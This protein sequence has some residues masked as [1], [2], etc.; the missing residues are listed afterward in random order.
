MKLVCSIVCLFLLVNTS[1]ATTYGWLI[2]LITG[3]N[4]LKP[5]YDFVVVGAGSAGSVVANRLTEN[6]AWKVL[7]V[8]AGDNEN[9]IQDVP[10][11]VQY[12]QLTNANWK[13]F[14]EPSSDYC[15]AMIDTKCSM[16]HG[17]VMGGSSA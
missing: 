14:S 6:A 15:Q 5:S 16:P 12:L 1:S 17:R 3:A 10:L 8:E 4:T 9:F 11:L 7:L 13:D 2:D